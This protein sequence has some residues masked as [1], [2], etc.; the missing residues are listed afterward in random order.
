MHRNPI[1][2]QKTCQK[3]FSEIEIT[4]TQRKAQQK[5]LDLI[6]NKQLEKEKE[7]YPIF[8]NTILRDLLG[9][10]EEEIEKAYEQKNVEFV[11]KDSQGDWA[12]LFEAKGMETSDL[13]AVQHRKKANQKTPIKQTFDNLTRFEFI[14][15]GVCTNYRKF[16]LLDYNLKFSAF[17]EFDFLSTKNDDE[18]LKEFIGIF[19]YKSL[20]INKDI[21]K[22]KSISDDADEELT[23]E[24]YKLFHETR[25][26]LMKAFKEKDNV[27]E[28]EALLY[29]QIFLE[30]ILFLFF[31][32]DNGLIDDPKLFRNRVLAQL[33]LNQCT[34]SSRKIFDDINLLFNALDT[35]DK[36]LNIHGFGGDLFSG[37]LPSKVYFLDFQTKQFFAN[38][39]MHSKLSRVLPLKGDAE[40]IWKQVGGNVSPIIRNL[41]IMDS[42]DFNSEINVTILGHILEQSLDD[43][44]EYEKSGELKR[45]IGGVYYTPPALTDYICRNTIIPYLSKNNTNDVEELILEYQENISELEEKIDRLKIID[46]ACGSGAFLI[47]AAIILLEITSII[48]VMK[49]QDQLASGTLDQWQQEQEV[50]KIIKN[51]IY[52]VDVNRNSVQITKLSLF[53]IMAKKG[54]TLSNLSKNI[55]IGNSLID[56]KLVD[57]QAFE[58]D[59][60]FPEIFSTGGFNIIIGNPPW[61]EVQPNIDEF[62]STEPEIKLQLS[63]SPKPIKKFSLLAKKQKLQMIKKCCENPEIER[64]YKTYLDDYHKRKEYFI[65]PNNYEL[66]VSTVKGKTVAGVGVNLAKLF[67]EKSL[68]LLSENGKLGLILP[69]SIYSQAG[70]KTLRQTLL[71]KYQLNH[72]IGFHNK[73]GIFKDVHRQKKFCSIIAT[74]ANASKKFLS[75]FFV[76]DTISCQ[77]FTSTAFEYNTEFVKNTSPEQLSFLECKDKIQ[78]QIFQKLF[79]FPFF[80]GNKWNL[81]ASREFNMSDDEYL[82]KKVEIGPPLFKGEMINFFDYKFSAP[83]YWI[84]EQEGIDELKRKETGRLPKSIRNNVTPQIHFDHYRLAWRKL[85]NPTNTRTCISTIL[86]P[87]VFLSDSLYFIHPIIFNGNKYEKQFSSQELIYLCGMLNTFVVDFIFRSK[88]DSN[89]TIL[90]FLDTPMPRFDEINTFHQK[91]LKNSTMLI[92]TT[93]DYTNL[94]NEI[95][96]SDY[97]DKSYPDRRIA[98]EAQINACAAKIFDLTYNELEYIF[99]LFPSNSLQQLKELTL[100]EFSLL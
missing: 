56:D 24:F 22:F 84:D 18:K 80:H 55:I 49:N 58:W 98:L 7:N 42:R 87:K 26:M 77:N 90:H 1:I 11:F 41:L 45:K 5:W 48:H 83:I 78:L 35:G 61:D 9:F 97:F 63:A 43:L 8:Q 10:P 46:P 27:S 50:S 96:I 65:D 6:E 66:Q 13:F 15:Y 89:L 36:F 93:T 38:E 86:P 64:R 47:N 57:P 33:K 28:Q 39:I 12:V 31:A 71:E 85:T 17:Q 59:K 75:K 62:F 20:V 70:C 51:N 67:L 94:R 44:G 72:I 91:I 79:K 30:R 74:S 54:E 3:L 81:K 34:S 32:S 2:S 16:V 40:K 88:I 4:E 25:L 92:C 53:L 68:S 14:K 29:S 100:D 21:S 52:G 69:E 73:L 99:E 95:G 37:K 60:K 76:T 19:S 82:F 23:T